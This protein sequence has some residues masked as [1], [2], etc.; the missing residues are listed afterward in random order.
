MTLALG[1]Q[2]VEAWALFNPRVPSAACAD[3]ADAAAKQNE[4]IAPR[5]ASQKEAAQN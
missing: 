1:L 5:E 3:A 2:T 4:A